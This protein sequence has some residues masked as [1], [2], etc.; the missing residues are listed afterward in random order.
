MRPLV[1]CDA[2][3][4]NGYAILYLLLYDAGTIRP[5]AKRD[6]EVM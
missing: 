6:W 3:P 4:R 5:A 1:V 2:G